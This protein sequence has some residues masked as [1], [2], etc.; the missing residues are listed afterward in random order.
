M[1]NS[2][3]ATHPLVTARHP[4]LSQALLAGASPQ[5]RN[6][7]M[8]GGNLLQR[9]RCHYF[10]DT[11]FN[12]CN[13]RQPGSRCGS[14]EVQS[15]RGV[16]RVKIGEFHRLPGTTPE[17]DTNL[18]G[19]ELITAVRTAAESVCGACV[20][21]EAARSGEP[22]LRPGIGRRGRAAGWTSCTGGSCCPGRR[23]IEAL[24]TAPARAGARGP[25]ARRC[26][27]EALA[28]Q[29]PEEARTAEYNRFKPELAKRGIIRAVRTAAGVV[30]YIT[31]MPKV[32]ISQRAES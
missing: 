20:L 8:V 1:R 18:G 11:G 15:P 7:A 16:R 3:L 26:D 10:Y 4:L 14:I 31:M 28:G 2:E 21:F 22:C 5:L 29:S 9:T 24:A 13:K 19:D 17:R 32:C 23:G 6:M 27:L 30:L 25:G 12:R